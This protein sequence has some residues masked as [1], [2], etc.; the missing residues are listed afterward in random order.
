MRAVR[1]P[2]HL[3]VV[4]DMACGAQAHFWHSRVAG[5]SGPRGAWLWGSEGSLRVADG[6]LYGGQRGDTD[7]YEIEVP[8]AEVGGWRVEQEFIN[9]IRGLEPVSHTPFATGVKYMEFTEAVARSLASGAAISLP[10]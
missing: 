7:L 5:L 3:D 2:E 10:L 9:A 1:I 8:L 4:A 6:R